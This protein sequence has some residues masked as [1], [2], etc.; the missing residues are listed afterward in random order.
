M[1]DDAA[2]CCG[3]SA[4]KAG[5]LDARPD[6]GSHVFEFD[7]VA[8]F[9]RRIDNRGCFAAWKEI[10]VEVVRA[11]QNLLAQCRNSTSDLPRVG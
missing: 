6:P 2:C 9:G 11:D 10:F 1:L 7:P 4:A 3:A 5:L 8:G